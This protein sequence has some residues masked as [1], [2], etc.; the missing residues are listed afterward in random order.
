[1]LAGHIGVGERKGQ[2][3]EEENGIIFAHSSH[4]PLVDRVGERVE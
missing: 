4:H 1:M 2:M 3:E